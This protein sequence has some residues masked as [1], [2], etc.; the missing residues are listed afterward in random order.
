MKARA[1]L[2]ATILGVSAANGQNSAADA[3]RAIREGELEDA[4]AIYEALYES[5]PRN[6]DYA[7][8]AGKTAFYLDDADAARDR[9]AVAVEL[10]PEYWDARAVLA[11]VYASIGRYDSAAAA[12]APAVEANP[13]QEGYARRYVEYLA[14]ADDFDGLRAA[15]EEMD[16][17][18]NTP[19]IADATRRLALRRTA[20]VAGAYHANDLISDWREAVAAFAVAPTSDF[21]V[22]TSL[23]FAE[24]FEE[25]E[26]AF[27]ALAYWRAIDWAVLNGGVAKGFERKYLPAW[28]L[29]AGATA[30]LPFGASVF[31]SFAYFEFA[32][33]SVRLYS[34]GAEAAIWRGSYARAQIYSAD[35]D[36]SYALSIGWRGE[37]ARAAVGYATSEEAYQTGFTSE[38]LFAETES[39]FIDAE[40]FFA[41]EWGVRLGVAFVDRKKSYES[42]KYEA[43]VVFK[44]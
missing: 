7:L 5:D 1:L 37:D 11:N 14:A 25:S 40:W 28:R 12:L 15:L 9:L 38:Q 34:A 42:G 16:R 41:V 19:P 13:E 2:I 21:S 36:A 20:R 26:A 4:R 27:S 30:Y 32:R 18:E 29:E 3:E 22:K 10:A 6:A 43:G 33:E 8:G 39:V 17:M 35:E 44:F 31:G 23:L 24:R